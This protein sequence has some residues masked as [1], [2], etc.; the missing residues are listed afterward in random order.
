MGYFIDGPRRL[1]G[2]KRKPATQTGVSEAFVST[3][4]RTFK[5]EI[6]IWE[7]VGGRNKC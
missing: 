5:V 2:G 4:G 1:F 6:G 7:A 3:M